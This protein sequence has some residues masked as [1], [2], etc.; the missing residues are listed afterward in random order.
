MTHVSKKKLD[1]ATRQKL[2]TRFTSL[3]SQISPAQAQSLFTEFF[4]EAERTMFI[5]RLAIILM[6][7]ED[8]STYRIARTLQVSDSTVRTLR[9]QFQAGAFETLLRRSRQ[10]DFDANAFWKTIENLLGLG[11]PPPA[12]RNRW[13]RISRLGSKLRD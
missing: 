8:H 4:S 13:Q 2:F 9:D 10:K 11:A 12:S 3:F 6:L 7:A 1:D 5:K